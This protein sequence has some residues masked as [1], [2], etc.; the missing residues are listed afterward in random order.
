MKN[1]IYALIVA[2]LMVSGTSLHAREFNNLKFP[3][4][5]TLAGTNTQLQLNGVGMRTKF[6][7]DVYIGALY[8]KSAAKTRDEVQAQEGPKRVL[9]HFVYDEVEAEKLAGG[10]TEG[11]E[12]NQ[13]EENFK[14]LN[15]RL[16]KFNA[17]FTT[18]HAGD[19]VLL[20]Y[21]PGKGTI[22]KIKGEQKGVIE[23]EDFY[24]ALLD[25]WLGDEPADDDLKEA[26]LG[27]ED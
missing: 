22:V 10:W 7:F 9:M 3:D 13:T 19:V 17:M 24:S 2:G 15:E 6:I 23:G 18:V 4:E 12:E 27:E 1:C 16:Q 20:D 21:I 25:V 8:T 5:V 11:F 26:M 14:K